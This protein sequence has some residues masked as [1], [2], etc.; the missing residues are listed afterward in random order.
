TEQAEAR[1]AERNRNK[2][3]HKAQLARLCQRSADVAWFIEE[4]LRELNGTPGNP[5]S[6]GELHGLIEAQAYRLAHWRVASDEI[7]YR[8]FF[9]IADLAA[10]RMENPDVFQA[11][12]Q[13]VF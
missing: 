12:H 5:A 10:L 6:F 3:I 7:N 11:T 4:N 9:D 13:L 8:R 1:L 2:E